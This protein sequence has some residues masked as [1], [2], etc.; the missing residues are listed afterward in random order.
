LPSP[1]QESA[2]LICNR[3]HRS[4][5]FWPVISMNALIWNLPQQDHLQT[6]VERKL[7]SR[8]LFCGVESA[9]V[10]ELPRLNRPSI[11]IEGCDP[12]RKLAAV[13]LAV[14]LRTNRAGA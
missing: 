3:P 10:T 13:C 9:R 12:A 6:L 7:H 5:N 4:P 14:F 8:R 1:V 11:R 2:R